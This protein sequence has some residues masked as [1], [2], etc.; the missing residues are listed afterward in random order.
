MLRRGLPPPP[1]PSGIHKHHGLPLRGSSVHERSPA[2]RSISPAVRIASARTAFRS[3]SSV[4][5]ASML[6][7]FPS[8]WKKYRGIGALSPPA[9]HRS[10]TRCL[11]RR[12]ALS[13]STPREHRGINISQRM[14][15]CV[16]GLKQTYFRVH[17]GSSVPHQP[18]TGEVSVAVLAAAPGGTGNL[19]FLGWQVKTRPAQ[20]GSQILAPGE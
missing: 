13:I 14:G 20:S 9:K 4:P 11:R 1:G 2:S 3:G 8:V 19:L 15:I 10:T 12:V 5:S 17:F 6:M 18:A 7:Y 16:G